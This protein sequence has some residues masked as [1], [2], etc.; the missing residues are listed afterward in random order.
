MNAPAQEEPFPADQQKPTG[1]SRLVRRLHLSLETLFG[2]RK[3]GAEE[4]GTVLTLLTRLSDRPRRGRALRAPS[5]GVTPRAIVVAL[6]FGVAAT[7]ANADAPVQPLDRIA[8]AVAERLRA[9]AASRWQGDPQANVEINVSRLDS[10]LRLPACRG[11]L[12]TELAPGARMIGSVA[13]GVRCSTPGWSLFVPA[14]VSVN[15][16]V[17]VMAVS[18]PRGA[19]LRETDLALERR[20]LGTLRAG[21]LTDRAEVVGM[22]LRR[23][24]QARVVLHAG[25]AEAPEL[26]SRGER[27]VLEAT[28][29]G[30]AVQVEGEALAGGALGQRVRVRNLATGRVVEGEVADK[31]LVTMGLPGAGR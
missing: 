13:V 31:G 4:N 16:P 14:R 27:I 3:T 22:Q 12:E 6:A 11:P 28:G 19:T 2:R 21:Y 7:A 23:P 29:G 30:I 15:R 20:D 10:R 18:R 9:E 24:V 5:A 25:L 1:R 26:V 17:V 8:S